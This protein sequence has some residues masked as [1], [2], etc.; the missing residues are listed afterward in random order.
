M[1]SAC[2]GMTV[3][4][5]PASAGQSLAIKKPAGGDTL[6]ALSLNVRRKRTLSQEDGQ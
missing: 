3:I 1:D 6:P 4:E 2:A 5:G